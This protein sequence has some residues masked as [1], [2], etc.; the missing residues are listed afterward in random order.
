MSA[1]PLVND[2][3]PLDVP[4]IG[5][6]L[7]GAYRVDGLLG[8]GGMGIIL[9]A[10]E[11]AADRPVAIKLMTAASAADPEQVARFRREAKAASSLTSKHVVRVLDFGELPSG[12]PYLVMEHLE[13]AP[14]VDLLKER[15]Q[16][17]VSEAV[18][19]VLQA[20]HGIAEA[21]ALGIV[22]RDLKP[23]NLFVTGDATAPVV[24]VIDFGASKLTAESNVDPSDPGGVT[25]ASSLI[26]SPRYMAPEQI[27]SALE[28]DAR[29][30]IYAL[31][32]TLHEVLSGK[33]IFFADTLA[34]IFAQVLWDEPEPLSATR[35]DV[36]AGLVEIISK[37][38]A[39]AP[40][41]RYAT[42]EALAVALAPF[43]PSGEVGAAEA[44]ATSASG[45]APAMAKPAAA[46][47]A[48]AKP[49]RPPP[50]V[51]KRSAVSGSKL[52]AARLFKPDDATAPAG[53]STV[54]G[55]PMPRK[56][57][58]T[59]AS[60]AAVVLKSTARMPRVK[61]TREA[62]KRTVRIAAFALAA[63]FAPHDD[64]GAATTEDATDR[65][66]RTVKMDRFDLPL[67][68]FARPRPRSR[69]PRALIVFAV[70]AAV[71]ALA[72][73]IGITRSRTHAVPSGSAHGGS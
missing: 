6:V 44:A 7:A 57:N 3:L 62:P 28:V 37:C 12:P 13:G 47:P 23:A 51:P 61:L 53:E 29:A 9:R 11:I 63:R 33:P 71:V 30:D 68:A 18:D 42:V 38:L 49:P 35:D 1:Q 64:D 34:R 69:F 56:R 10:T 46:K 40:A 27:R 52:V 65:G 70:V 54:S 60:K 26:G 14:L 21:H 22:H 32:A 48:P 36:P 41:D 20:I 5:T 67:A 31:G 2:A 19:Y 25:I 8:N 73:A 72:A 59:S 15:G 66:A 24:K 17:R 50:P 58:G 43:G 39:K 4:A 16:L 45:M 55:R